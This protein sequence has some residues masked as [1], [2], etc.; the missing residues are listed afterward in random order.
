MPPLSLVPF[1]AGTPRSFSFLRI[2]AVGPVSEPPVIGE[3]LSPRALLMPQRPLPRNPPSFHRKKKKLS[4][5]S[6]VLLLEYYSWEHWAFVLAG[7]IELS[8]RLFR[9]TGSPSVSFCPL[10]PLGLPPE[11]QQKPPMTHLFNNVCGAPVEGWAVSL[12]NPCLHRT[13][14]CDLTWKDCLLWWFTHSVVPDYFRPHGLQHA[15]PPC[16]SQSP[17]VC[18]SSCPLSQQCY[19]TISSSA[20]SSPFASL[21]M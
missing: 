2:T 6:K 8:P 17:R 13:S 15:R 3:E 21:R 19:P 18:L 16:P 9:I 12:K 14:E 4:L 7:K 20:S 10:L 5:F 11:G 1:P